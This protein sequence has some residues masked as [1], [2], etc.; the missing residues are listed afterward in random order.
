MPQNTEYDKLNAI[1][2]QTGAGSSLDIYIFMNVI[3]VAYMGDV[4]NRF[5]KQ[6]TQ[7]Q[8]NVK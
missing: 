3:I 7:D 5:H 6:L 4:Y 8:S 1:F 2:N